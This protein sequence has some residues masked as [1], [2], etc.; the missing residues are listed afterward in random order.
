MG[1]QDPLTLAKAA[2]RILLRDEA[3]VISSLEGLPIGLFPEIF[4]E[5]FTERRTNVLRAMAHA[6]PFPC[7]PAGAL[8]K[9]LGLETLRI[10]LEGLDINITGR[11][12]PR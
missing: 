9:N 5:A 6:W 11:L 7:L 3:S 12:H 4:E 8:L 2:T 10:L 1:G